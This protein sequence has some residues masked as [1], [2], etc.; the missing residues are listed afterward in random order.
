M[1]LPKSVTPA[2]IASN[3]LGPLEAAEKLKAH[4]E[5]I[6]KLDGLAASGKQH[7]SAKRFF[8]PLIESYGDRTVCYT[9]SFTLRGELNLDSRTGLKERCRSLEAQAHYTQKD[10]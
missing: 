5:D 9:G 1:T 10:K 3:Y 7:R 8:F 2:R 6:A 4:P